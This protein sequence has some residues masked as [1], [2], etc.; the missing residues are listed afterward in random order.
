MR[1][2]QYRPLAQHVQQQTIT[3]LVRP[4]RPRDFSRRCTALV[5]LSCLALAAAG[6]RSLA[7]IAA[8]RP[9]APCRETR[10]QALLATLPD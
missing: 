5:L 3:R 10:R 7:A 1:T 9:R 8:L 2:P 6:R 4:L